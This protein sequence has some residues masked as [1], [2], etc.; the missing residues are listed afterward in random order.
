ML[1]SSIQG[2]NKIE[3]T[4]LDGID[5]GLKWI[6][7]LLMSHNVDS[8][9]RA[10]MSYPVETPHFSTKSSYSFFLF[11]MLFPLLLFHTRLYKSVR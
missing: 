2:F 8:M 3:I 6:P 10:S 5:P 9:Q 4:A 11:A 7:Y 1:H